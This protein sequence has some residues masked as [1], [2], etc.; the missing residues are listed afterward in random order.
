MA[1]KV[2]PLRASLRAFCHQDPLVGIEVGVA[3]GRN[4]ASLLHH[5]REL[6]V[7]YLVDPYQAYP[8]YA[9]YQ[10]SELDEFLVKA[11][12][13]VAAAS[14]HRHAKVVW[15]R[16]RFDECTRADFNEAF[17]DFIYIDGNHSLE[18]VKADIRTALLFI[19]KPGM[20]C[21]HDFAAEGVHNAVFKVA[22]AE[23]K[24]V[25][26]VAAN[27]YP[28]GGHDWWFWVL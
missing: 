21:G 28:D 16:K 12:A 11:Q 26:Y 19:R 27:P 7:L 5:I 20:I 22:K 24:D 13:R 6:G 25:V 15:V 23:S 8:E 17:A 9:D 10:Q 3:D 2:Q 1:S 14:R 4:A 18:G